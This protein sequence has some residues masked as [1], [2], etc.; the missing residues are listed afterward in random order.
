MHTLAEGVET[1]EQYEFL[2]R[3]GCE[4]MQGYLFGK[5][6]PLDEFVK[7]DDFSFDNCEDIK[8]KKYYHEIGGI[9]LLGS[10]P[11]RE[12]NMEVYNNLPIAIMELNGE[13]MKFI[14]ANNAY[15]EFLHSVSI[16]D[17]DEA[18]RRTYELDIPETSAMRKALV[19]AENDPSHIS[20]TDVIINGNVIVAKTRF[21]VREGDKAAFIVVPRNLSISG[22]EQ[23]LA[24][25]IHVAMAHVFEQYFRVDLF[26]ED[27]TADNIFL[28][29]AQTAVAD[30]EKNTVKAV[31]MYADLYLY[32]EDRQRFKD[33]Y[34]ITTVR[35]RVEKSKR[36]YLVDYFHSAIPGDNGRLQMYMILPFYYNDRWKYI[37]CCRYADEINDEFRQQIL[38]KKD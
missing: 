11:L 15:I 9:N 18:N 6:T 27:G 12:K 19:K 17:F 38:Q 34:D 26:D 14:Y 1:Q 7:P 22:S 36:D 23:K 3:I 5:P 32:P 35:K 10:T 8:Y 21:V 2:K 37:S 13:K 30:I 33:F 25:N 31:S 20:D 24:G 16:K 4:K 28:N 29:G